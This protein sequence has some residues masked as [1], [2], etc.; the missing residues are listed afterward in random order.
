MGRRTA[1]LKTQSEGTV[2]KF[3]IKEKFLAKTNI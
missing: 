1:K 3:L 2:N